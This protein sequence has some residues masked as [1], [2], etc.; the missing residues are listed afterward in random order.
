MMGGPR[1]KLLNHGA[2]RLTNEELIAIVLRTGSSGQN[3]VRTATLLLEKYEG[4][5]KKL[6][7]ASLEELTEIRGLG[8]VKAITIKA[9]M[10][11]AKR[12]VR[13]NYE[14][15]VLNKPEKVYE[16]CLDMTFLKQE[17]VRVILLDSKLKA[18]SYRDVTLGTV[19]SSLV[20][21]REIFREAIRSG[22]VSII[23]VHNHPSGE[24]SPSSEDIKATQ[25]I[26][27]AGKIIDIELVDHII[28]GNGYY[29]FK[30]KGLL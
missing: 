3:V 30:Q 1:E 11:I 22:A 5:L 12:V 9:V 2:E 13:E 26:K 4:S 24:V 27:E 20:H 29:S 17:T 18:F 10:E 21:P 25:K 16:Y 28:V 7:D 19:T 14:G 23:M 6:A 15:R 8:V